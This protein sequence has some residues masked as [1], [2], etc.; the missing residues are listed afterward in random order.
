METIYIII[1]PSAKCDIAK[2]TRQ[3]P[4]KIWKCGHPLSLKNNHSQQTYFPIQLI[5]RLDRVLSVLQVQEYLTRFE[6]I[7][8]ML[9]LD[10]LTVS[11]DVTFG[12]HVSLKVR[13]RNILPS[14]IRHFFVGCFTVLII[15]LSSPG[16]SH[17][18][19]QPWRPN[20]HSGWL[21][22]GKQNSVW[23]PSD[24]G[25]LKPLCHVIWRQNH[26]TDLHLPL[27]VSSS[28]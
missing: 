8:D 5:L 16:N 2:S 20:R 25:P 12:K 17:Y 10:H 18:H 7:P 24:P 11:G 14:A 27:S 15:P 9:E 1:S 13:A 4:T 22:V 26:M 3:K 6:S 21:H 28:S 23:K 19:S